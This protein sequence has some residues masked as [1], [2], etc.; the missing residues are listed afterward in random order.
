MKKLIAVLV[1]ALLP[2]FA[3]A[4][5][6]QVRN[7]NLIYTYDS[8]QTY[9]SCIAGMFFLTGGHYATQVLNANGQPLTCTITVRD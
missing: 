4:Y 3:N 7:G 9:G 2:T 6:F 5:I 8:Y 1:L